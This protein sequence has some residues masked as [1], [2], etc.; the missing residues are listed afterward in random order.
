MNDAFP[1]RGR[2]HSSLGEDCVPCS[3]CSSNIARGFR[4]AL[5]KGLDTGV[6]RCSIRA[7]RE[8]RFGR[9]KG[10]DTGVSRVA[11]RLIEGASP[12]RVKGRHSGE[13]DI[14]TRA[15]VSIP[16]GRVWMSRF[17]RGVAPMTPLLLFTSLRGNAPYTKRFQPC[18]Y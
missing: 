9:I 2:L 10:L 13:W 8:V 6:S 1:A 11:T 4:V 12:A 18:S 14:S 16:L 15:S 3:R 7:Y 17:F 5:S